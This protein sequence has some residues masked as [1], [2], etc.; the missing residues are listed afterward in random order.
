M[1]ILL[2]GFFKISNDL[3]IQI[4][5]SENKNGATTWKLLF[6]GGTNNFS[7]WEG[8]SKFLARGGDSPQ[9]PRRENP[10]HLQWVKMY[11]EWKEFKEFNSHFDINFRYEFLLETKLVTV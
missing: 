8:I 4:A 2:G 11:K 3:F 6:S 10:E 7:W 9:P 1:T 5:W